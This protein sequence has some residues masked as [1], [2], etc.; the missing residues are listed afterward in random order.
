MSTL[1]KWFVGGAL[2]AAVVLGTAYALN[3]DSSGPEMSLEYAGP[4]DAADLVQRSHAIVVA[5]I[6]RRQREAVE[7]PYG[8]TPPAQET[9]PDF[10][11]PDHTVPV[12]YYE[13]QVEETLLSDGRV[14]ETIV[15]RV[16]GNSYSAGFGPQPIFGDR[17]L[18]SMHVTPDSTAYTTPFGWG[19]L[20]LDGSVES[21]LGTRY[22]PAF[23]ENMGAT[24]AIASVR[25]AARSRYPKGFRANHQWDGH[26]PAPGFVLTATRE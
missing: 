26:C 6:V 15:L 16:G 8:G 4:E 17:Y 13:L 9:R 18:V 11:T 14:G 24:Q 20:S 12:T 21:S 2:A 1:G 10:P 25:S 7:G 22:T 23:L 5:K 3:R 19:L